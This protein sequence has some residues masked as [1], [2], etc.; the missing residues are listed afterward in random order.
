[1]TTSGKKD[2][3]RD[4]AIAKWILRTHCPIAWPEGDRCLNCAESHPCRSHQWGRKVLGEAAWTEADIAS[5]DA[6]SGAWS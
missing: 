2:S 3:D 6:R 1:M 4:I 5:L